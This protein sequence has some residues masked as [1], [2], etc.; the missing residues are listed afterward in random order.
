MSPFWRVVSRCVHRLACSGF[1]PIARDCHNYPHVLLQSQRTIAYK[2]SHRSFVDLTCIQY[3]STNRFASKLVSLTWQRN[4]PFGSLQFACGPGRRERIGWLL[5]EKTNELVTTCGTNE[6]VN[7][8]GWMNSSL[9]AKRIHS[10][11]S[12]KRMNSL[13]REG[14]IVFAGAAFI[15]SVS[16]ELKSR[17]HLHPLQKRHRPPMRELWS[18]RYW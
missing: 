9:R 18:A 15:V 7:T 5:C 16:F 12:E 10:L 2:K 4:Y 17:Y 6:L 8:C 3:L 13:L 11:L 1:V 14:T